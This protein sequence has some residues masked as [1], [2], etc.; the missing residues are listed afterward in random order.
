MARAAAVPPPP[1]DEASPTMA[2]GW[3]A[4]PERGGQRYWD[5]KNWTDYRAE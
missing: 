3:Y 2:P 4:D 1:P 5:G